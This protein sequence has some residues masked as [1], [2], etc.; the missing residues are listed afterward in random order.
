MERH[1]NA[2][3]QKNYIG[4]SPF[5]ILT[6]TAFTIFNDNKVNVGV[7]EVGMGGKLDSTN[8]LNNQ[9]ISVISKIARDHEGFLGNTLAEIASHKAGILRPSVPYIIS[10]ANEPNVQAVV[11]DYAREIGAGSRLLPYSFGLQTKL[12]DSSKWTR[13]TSRMMPFQIENLKLAV[14]AVR[15]ALDGM[16]RETKPAELAKILLQNAKKHIPGRQEIV[17]LTPV[18]RRA[19]EVR[20]HVLVDGAHNPDAAVTLA[21]YVKANL[22]FGKSPTAGR[23]ESGWPVTWVLAMTEGKDAKNYLA[24]LLKPGDKVVTTTFG[25]VDGMPWVKPMNSKDLLELAKSVEPQITGV[26]VPIAGALRAACTAKYMTDHIANWAPIA[27]TGSL[28]LV[29]DLHRELRTRADKSWWTDEDPVVAA[30]R[31]SFLQIQADERARAK[32]VLE[33]GTDEQERLQ[34]ELDALNREVEQ[35]EIEEKRITIEQDAPLAADNEMHMSAAE[36]LECEEERFVRLFATPEQLVVRLERVEKVK[37]DLA[38]QQETMQAALAEQKRKREEKLAR[39]ARMEERRERKFRRRDE[40]RKFGKRDEERKSMTEQK[41][42]LLKRENIKATRWMARP[43]K[44]PSTSDMG[45]EDALPA[46]K[47]TYESIRRLS[48]DHADDIGDSSRGGKQDPKA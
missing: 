24:T 20:N 3:N 9:V 41:P 48:L 27:I 2:I 31:E 33:G 14:I 39:R 34:D 26:H 5:E 18:F 23:P 8:I 28:Y 15:Q 40:E 11:E 13:A 19:G 21:E 43:V 22:R 35:L 46:G 17:R 10:T 12:Y 16:A 30:D 1:Y 37:A 29:G 36:R 32:S 4:A 42:H 6:A 25:P 38:R 45:H 47:K 7:V 44:D